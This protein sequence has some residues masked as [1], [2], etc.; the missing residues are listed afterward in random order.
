MITRLRCRVPLVAFAA[1]SGDCGATCVGLTQ[2]LRDG[3]RCSGECRGDSSTG[4]QPSA[5]LLRPDDL[6]RQPD[7]RPLHAGL[8]GNSSDRLTGDPL[9]HRRGQQRRQCPRNLCG[10]P[11]RV[12]GRPDADGR[13]T[14]PQQHHHYCPRRG[15]C[16]GN[17]LGLHRA[18]HQPRIGKLRWS[19]PDKRRLL[20]RRMELGGH[21]VLLVRL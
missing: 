15:H 13:G 18:G 5:H 21:H 4:G 3:R 1:R 2:H 16:D 6:Q 11:D 12:L 10:R 8:C 9:E 20:L 14:A 17:E 7:G 19:Q